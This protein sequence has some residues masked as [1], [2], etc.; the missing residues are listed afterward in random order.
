MGEIT[1]IISYHPSAL[2]KISDYNPQAKM[3]MILRN[4]IARAF[5]HWNMEV[6]RGNEHKE[7]IE[8][9]ALEAKRITNTNDKS[10]MI[11]S[12]VDRGYYSKQINQ[13]NVHFPKKQTLYIKYEDY[14]A[15]PAI[16]LGSIYSFLKVRSYAPI[17]KH[18]RAHTRA[19][20]RCISEEEKDRL[21]SMYTED[22]KRVE[23]LLGWD[24]SDWLC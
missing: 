20:Q 6:D 12:Y 18:H 5:S 3:I 8:C 16:V 7:F 11:Y 24:C 19:Y 15:K 21:I 4:P 13:I 17:F 14:V 23:E 1:P 10:R 2:A 9:V 22:I